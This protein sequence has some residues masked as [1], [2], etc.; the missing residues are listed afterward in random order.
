MG[1]RIRALLFTGLVGGWGG[2]SEEPRG[3]QQTGLEGL[4]LTRVSP[5]VIVPGSRIQ[6]DGRS[7]VDRPLA[8]SWLHLDGTYAQAPID[9][10]IPARFVDFEQMEIEVTADVLG[11]L[12]PSSGDFVGQLRLEVDFVPEGT[13]HASVP[14]T[15][16]L[17]VAE[18]LQPELSQLSANAVIFVNEPIEVHGAGLLLGG[19]EGTTV[20]VVEGC[21]TPA[22]G[23]SCAPVGPVSVPVQPAEPFSR[24]H[25]IFAFSPR[26]AGIHPGQFMGE[27]T[28]RNEHADGEVRTSDGQPLTAELVPTRV[29][30]VS[31]AADA[32]EGEPTVGTLGKRLVVSGG[33]FVGPD[34]GGTLLHF[35]GDYT[36]DET[37]TSQPLTFDV[38][39]E[40]VDGRTVRYVINEEDALGRAI[41]LR[42]ARGEFSGA[43]TPSIGFDGQIVE[44][45]GTPVS[46]RLEPVKQVVFV[47]WNPTYVESLRLF[48]LRALDAAVRERVLAV[49]RRDYAGVNVEFRTEPPEDYALYS[50]IEIAGPDPNGLGLLGYDNT[51][52]KDR[53]N[54]RLGDRIGGINAQT[55]EDGLPGFGGVF[56]ESL[57]SF[58]LHPPGGTV[59]S[60]ELA[61][62]S[63]DDVFDPFRPDRGQPVTDDDLA[64]GIPTFESAVLCPGNDRITR[65]GCAVFVLGSVVGSTVSH[66]LGHSLGLADPLGTEFHNDGD[67]PDRL[68]DAGGARG[69]DERAQLRGL[70]PSRFCVDAYAYLREILPTSEPEPNVERPPC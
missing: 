66:E 24:D 34:D 33:G 9:I 26:I 12:G 7:F 45:E 30:A 44:G 61:T 47:Q 46:F 41:E 17:S 8:I 48:G 39:P 57:F 54:E 59:A 56:M 52:G 50:T 15:Q 20:A 2:C 22:D 70:G 55:L 21:F 6:L 62:A 65:I 49:L 4:A 18:H 1:G 27:V 58:S 35:S 32:D 43:L 28:L 25:G 53:G 69:F 23:G 19:D 64:T 60:G 42:Q 63:F 13:R 11:L 10:Y 68:M 3:R 14:L 31:N 38:I 36:H 16:S 51:P 37:S 40:Y 5:A 67:A 29:T